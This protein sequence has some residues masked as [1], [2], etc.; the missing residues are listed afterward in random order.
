CRR[1]VHAA[2]HDAAAAPTTPSAD[3]PDAVATFRRGDVVAGRYVIERYIVRGGMGEVYEAFDR[4]L[5]M[6]VALKTLTPTSGDDAQA[7]RRLKAEVQ[8]ARR[9]SHPNVCRIFD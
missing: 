3:G 2:M 4:E 8:L 7:V 5:A 9:V 1:I 6:R